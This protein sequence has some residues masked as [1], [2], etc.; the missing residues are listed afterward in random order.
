MVI[1][2]LNQLTAVSTFRGGQ[3]AVLKLGLCSSL[4]SATNWPGACEGAPLFLLV[5]TH[6]QNEKKNVVSLFFVLVTSL[7]LEQNT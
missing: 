6:P 4:A 7:L 2:N 3:K 5:S 1:I